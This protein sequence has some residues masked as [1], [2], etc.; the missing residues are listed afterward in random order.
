MKMGCEQKEARACSLLAERYVQGRGVERDLLKGVELYDRGCAGNWA[1]ACQKNGSIYANGGYSDGTEIGS[2][3][4][5]GG[6]DLDRSFSYHSKA[7]SL[8]LADGCMSVAY[9]YEHGEH[10]AKNVAK[11]KEMYESACGKGSGDGCYGAALLLDETNQAQERERLITKGCKLRG[12]WACGEFSNGKHDDQCCA[13]GALIRSCE[14][15]NQQ[16]CIAA[17]VHIGKPI[18]ASYLERCGA[19]KFNGCEFLKEDVPRYSDQNASAPDH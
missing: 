4:L 19:A 5:P 6:P 10:V 16:A 18:L 15:N 9:M 14:N 17:S 3:R 2:S 1:V 12:A 7:C 8:D 13:F 11:A